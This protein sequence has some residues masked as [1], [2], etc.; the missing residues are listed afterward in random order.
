MSFSVSPQSL[1][2]N[3]SQSLIGTQRYHCVKMTIYVTAFPKKVEF[4]WKFVEIQIT[5]KNY[6]FIVRS[7]QLSTTQIVKNVILK[8]IINYTMTASNGI[9]PGRTYI[10]QV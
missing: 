2:Y 5:N 8:H 10:L 7:H 3:E 9:V 1:T 6:D 4:A